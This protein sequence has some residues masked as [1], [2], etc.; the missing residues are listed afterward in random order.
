MFLNYLKSALRNITKNKF[1][2]FL[3]IL[4]LAIGIAAFIFIFLYVRNEISFDKY[5]EKA[6]RIYRVESDFTISG[7]HDQF[8]IVPVPMGPALKLEFP[9]VEEMCRF[10]DVGNSLFKYGDKEFYE[11]G[12]YF[13]DSTIFDIFTH[14]VLVG[15]PKSCL[16]EP[17]SVVITESIAM[18]FFGDQNPMGEIMESGSG[19][20]YKVTAIMED[21]PINSHLKFDALLS[22]STIAAIQGGDAFNSMEPVRFWNIG[23][24]TFLLLNQNADMQSVH[25]K[26]G[27]FY[28]KYMKPV[29]DAINASFDLMSTPLTNTHFSGN[30][31][32]DLPKGNMA[33]I[34]I[35][36]AVA[37]FILLIAAINYMNMATAR[38]AKRAR[39]V[40]IRKVAGA[41]KKQLIGQFLSESL[42]LALIGFAI[43]LLLVFL[44]LPDFNNLAG[45]TLEFDLFRKPELFFTILGVTVF[46]GLIS[47][48]YPAFY[49]SSFLPVTVLKGGSGDKG[50]KGGMLRKVLVIFQ[51]AIA[52]IMIMGTL[53][54]YNQL[55]F[56][57]NKDMG[58][59]KDNMIILELQDSA[60]RSKVETFKK[61]LVK[62]SN[63]LA[64]TN[65]TGIPG[66][67]SWIQVVKMEKDTAMV[68]NA[69]LLTLVDYDYLDTYGLELVEGR[70]FDREMGTDLEE[71]VIVNETTVKYYNWTDNPIGKKIHWGFEMD[72]SGGRILKV[73]GVVK[74][75]HFNSLHNKVEPIMLFMADFD[76][77]YVSLKVNPENI[78]STLQYIEEKWNEF[79]AKRPF[80]YRMLEDTWG[81]MYESEQKLG[82]IFTISTILTIFIALLGLL[83]LSSFVAEQKTKE[84][85]IRKV[86]GATLGNVLALLYKEFV[87]L[88]IIA[89]IIAIP[90][91]YWQLDNWL[92]TSFVYHTNISILTILLSGV[93]AIIISM[94]TISF[95]TLKAGMSNPVDAIKYE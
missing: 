24:Y 66:D 79:G 80:N 48:S 30:I 34:Y 37:L 84:I 21:V 86:M 91:A 15:D 53:I 41:F 14:K 25:Q 20:K 31:S 17:Y 65:S 95:H 55:T 56:L 77:Y 73:I 81:E 83:G 57:K 71:A 50:R 63:I 40:G 9:E 44:L 39:E 93:L 49:L 7:K 72:G 87:L 3:N 36:S 29:G 4:G 23:V 22:G 10:N 92:Q 52:I 1:Y 89:F 18:K 64:A 16:V 35:F 67:N 54:V 76:K 78:G 13:V 38:S 70:T 8:A 33:Y 62:N 69:M 68:D 26:F 6:D 88:V 19:R 45:K 60:F 5:H 11:D 2:S 27:G 90:L 47:G 61:E 43:A 51:F 94:V 42:V 59:N 82:V 58:F 32:S 74:D 28:D 46:I 75:Y 12:F 85:G